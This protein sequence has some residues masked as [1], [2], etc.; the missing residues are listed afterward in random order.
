MSFFQR[1]HEQGY[2]AMQ[3]FE[4]AGPII[5]PMYHNSGISLLSI[6]YSRAQVL[7]SGDLTNRDGFDVKQ[8]RS[9]AKVNVCLEHHSSHLTHFFSV[10]CGSACR[11]LY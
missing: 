8:I 2:A 7:S 6:N 4:R 3:I 5:D 9:I 10:S 1:F 11:W